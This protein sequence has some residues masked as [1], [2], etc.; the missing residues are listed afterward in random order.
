MFFYSKKSLSFLNEVD[1]LLKTLALNVL[2]YS[3]IDIAIVEGKRTDEQQLKKY[4]TRINGKRVTFCDG[5]KN[6][7]K[8][9]IPKNKKNDPNIK[10]EA[11]D[12][13]CLIKGKITYD[14]KYYYYIVG[15][16]ESEARKLGINIKC[17]IW[18]K[19]KDGKPFEDGGHVEKT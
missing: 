3:Y 2:K 15:L 6:R 17:G 19:D 4:N 12:F 5:I 11:F 16:M 9:Q 10:V 13:V 14:I 8:H 1:P 7:S 18:F